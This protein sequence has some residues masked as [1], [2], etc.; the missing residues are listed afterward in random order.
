M[1]PLFAILVAIFVAAPAAMAQASPVDA[2]TC[3]YSHA[4]DG[5]QDRFM[6]V[7]IS[8]SAVLARFERDGRGRTRESLL[9]RDLKCVQAKSDPMVVSCR[10]LSPPGSRMLTDATLTILRHSTLSP[11]PIQ[12]AGTENV[13]IISEH[14]RLYFRDDRAPGLEIQKNFLRPTCRPASAAEVRDAFHGS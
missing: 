7:G 5:R 14:Y 6:L 3:T 13:D 12:R 4:P 9:A 2:L 11:G 8:G 10:R 1:K